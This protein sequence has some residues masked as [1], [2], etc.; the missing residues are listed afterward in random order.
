MPADH[1]RHRPLLIVLVLLAISVL[2]DRYL[3]SVLC[4]WM[5]ALGGTSLMVVFLDIPVALPLIDP[6]PVAVLFSLFYSMMPARTSEEGG[7]SGIWGGVFIL[8]C[9]MAAGALLY[10]FV[11]QF[12]PRPVRNGVDSFGINIDINTSLAEYGT[13]HCRGGIILLLCFILGGR[14]LLKRI[15]RAAIAHPVALPP[16]P[17]PVPAPR[18]EPPARPVMTTR[19]TPVCTTI[20]SPPP[21]PVPVAPRTAVKSVSVVAPQ[22]VQMLVTTEEPTPLY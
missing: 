19:E 5:P 21:K 12:L 9:W 18:K 10:H 16:E 3:I 14:T 2:L 17:D 8:A 13:L 6:L 4:P 1:G 11:E 7:L 15:R 20:A 22:R